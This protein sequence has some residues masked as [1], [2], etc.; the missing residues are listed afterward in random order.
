MNGGS[1]GGNLIVTGNVNVD[2]QFTINIAGDLTIKGNLIIAKELVMNITGNL[3][4]EGNITVA[5]Q[6]S[7][8][9]DGA[10]TVEGTA[11]FAK[12]SALPGTGT[13][14]INGTCTSAAPNICADSQIN[15]LLPIELLSINS[16]VNAGGSSVQLY[17]VTATEINNDYFTIHRTRDGKIFTEIG[18]IAGAGK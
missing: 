9:V 12:E 6:A 8:T 15:G 7:M 1:S 4:V 16:V 11:T 13:V 18:R 5:K 2:K 14:T 10:M 3:I 17:W